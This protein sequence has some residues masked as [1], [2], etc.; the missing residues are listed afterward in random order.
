MT[1]NLQNEYKPN[2][3]S[4]PG[5][6]LLETLET[7][8]MSQAELGRQ[9]G[10][11]VETIHEL[12]QGTITITEEIAFQLE[13]ILHIPASFWLN[14]ERFYRKSLARVAEEDKLVSWEKWAD[15][16]PV[17][18][19]MEYSWFPECANKVQLVA[20]LLIFFGVKS[21]DAW[22]EVWN[23]KVV[24]YRRSEMPGRH[25][26]SLTAWLREGELEA[27]EI[28]CAPYDSMK[29]Q[30]ALMRIRALTVE[31]I[32]DFK[33]KLIEW[34]A[35]AGVAV[36]F[37]RE[38]PNIGIGGTTQWIEPDKALI[39]LSLRYKTDDEFWFTFFHEAGHI[40]L[41]GKR[42]IFLEIDEAQSKAAEQEADNFSKNT[43]VDKNQWNF[44]TSS[45]HSFSTTEIKK[46]AS[47]VEVAP[48]IIVGRL[49][50]EQLLSYTEC[51]EL[52]RSLVWSEI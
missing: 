10:R 2:F 25:F 14:R 19:L 8:G 49:Q 21:P 20:T 37:V 7:I 18:Q 33:E 41:H 31:P 35:N 51:N 5:E 44:F 23:N 28:E 1:S 12:I 50:H 39:Q 22:R 9:M 11:P 6:T 36:V 42:Q 38:L 17:E 26:G 34:C 16:F 52:K 29:F 40:L 32:S 46:F 24:A 27:E 15:D 3:V 48:G 13:H 45:N 47:E 4:V 43:L 30:D